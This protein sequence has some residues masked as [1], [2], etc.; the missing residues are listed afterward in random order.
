MSG[1]KLSCFCGVVR[2]VQMMSMRRMSVVRSLLYI[3]LFVG[4]CRVPMVFC[5]FFVVISSFLVV[6]S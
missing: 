6:F 5:R 1:V 4:F 3:L 2:G